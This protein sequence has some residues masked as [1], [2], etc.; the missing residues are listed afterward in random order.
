MGHIK[1]KY[2]NSKPVI[3][4]I[5]VKITQENKEITDGHRGGGYTE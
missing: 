2:E 1:K 5:K 3:T 4:V